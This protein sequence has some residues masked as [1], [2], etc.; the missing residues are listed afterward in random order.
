MTRKILFATLVSIVLVAPAAEAADHVDLALQGL[1]SGPAE[2]IKN[3]IFSTPLTVIGPEFRAAA[4][5]ALPDVI[6]NGRIT[7][8]PVLRR[9]EKAFAQVL[10]LYGRGG[11]IEIVLYKSAD[12]AGNALEGLCARHLRLARCPSPGR[13]TEGSGRARSG[14][15]LS[16]K[17]WRR[18]RFEG[19]DL[20][21]QVIEPSATVALLTLKL[22]GDDPAHT[23]ERYQEV[24]NLMDKQGSREDTVNRKE[25]RR[26]TPY[27][28]SIM[29]RA[30]FKE[31][32]IKLDP[33]H[34]AFT[35]ESRH[36]FINKFRS[37]LLLLLFST[38]IL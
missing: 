24:N 36:V 34:Y 26:A 20:A 29:E 8:G 12:P 23:P 13:G 21:M 31:R 10:E 1:G 30:Q 3:R 14:P 32:F 15:L 22:L 37:P 25:W 2:E 17:G 11:T 19:Y 16:W 9:A 33:S 35:K 38:A 4:V 27:Q 6:R 5:V 7:F 18:T 28:P